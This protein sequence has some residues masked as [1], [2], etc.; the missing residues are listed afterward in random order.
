MKLL[1]AGL[2]FSTVAMAQVPNLKS[3]YQGALSNCY[4][5]ELEKFNNNH[6][7]NDRIWKQTVICY[8]DAN[9]KLGANKLN[10]ESCVD[11]KA[12]RGYWYDQAYCMQNIILSAHKSKGVP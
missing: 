11:A 3:P 10:L 7:N 2:L 4:K 8:D 6:Y 1:F 5:S 9:F 12:R